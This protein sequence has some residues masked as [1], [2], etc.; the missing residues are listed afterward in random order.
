MSRKDDLLWVVSDLI[1][2]TNKLHLK[3]AKLS[4][5]KNNMEETL[6]NVYE[7]KLNN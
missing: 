4:E 3:E 7:S 6:L 2:I 1:K 5:K